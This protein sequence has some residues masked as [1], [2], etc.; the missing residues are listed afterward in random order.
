MKTD[1]MPVTIILLAFSWIAA[2]SAFSIAVY[3]FIFKFGDVYSLIKGIS[4]LLGGLLLACAI[5]MFGNIGQILCDFK[6]FFMHD[7]D[8]M[9]FQNIKEIRETLRNGFI[10]LKQSSQDQVEE[11]KK[12]LGSLGSQA[13]EIR[14]TLRNGFINLNRSFQSQAKETEEVLRNGFIS[15]GR[16]SQNQKKELSQILEQMNCDLRDINQS[17]HQIKVFFEE[18]ER[19]LDFK[20]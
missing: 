15:L 6:N 1:K 13:E 8:K 16:S 20:K 4:I 9:F 11:T 5:R 14:E 10:N 7:F 18:I 12:A 17:I 19:H 3:F 2:I